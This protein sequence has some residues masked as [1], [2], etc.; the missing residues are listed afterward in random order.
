MWGPSP[1]GLTIHIRQW[2]IMGSQK[3]FMGDPLY[4]LEKTPASSTSKPP[5]KQPLTLP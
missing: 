2:R 4:V 5:A 1:P 3:Y